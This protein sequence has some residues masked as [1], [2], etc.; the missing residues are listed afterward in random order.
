MRRIGAH[1]SISGG[2]DAAVAR[3]REAG[4]EALQIFSRNPR[5]WKVSSIP[6]ERADD[7]RR[8]CRA[9][10]L[11]PVVVHS[12]YLINLSAPDRETY[13][14]SLRAFSRD[15]AR[16]DALGAD[17]YVVHVGFHRGSGR[18]EGI[19]RMADSLR[20]LLAERPPGGAGVMLE[21][22]ASVGSALGHCFENIAR[23]M[24]A[25]GRADRLYLCLDTCHAFVAGYDLAGGDGPGKVLAEVDRLIGL[26]K[27]PVVHFNDS[28]FGLGS[29]RD[30]HA[31][32][33]EGR[34][35][36]EGMRR[37]YRHRRLA[38]KTFI[39]ET[40]QKEPGDNARNVAAVKGFR[41]RPG[42]GPQE[43]R[44]SPGSR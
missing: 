7:F 35:G 21:N 18:E 38:G 37:I 10:R 25:S 6:A 15:L 14:R 33:G 2:V 20:E 9:A 41:R 39:L 16:A 32:I 22:T 4:C 11:F 29:G 44:S 31:H 13:R 1:V 17:W 3:A 34:I 40:P 30:R 12:P 26:E 28:L 36:L 43:R 23:I 42:S 27:M 24:E 19:A 5:G 8:L